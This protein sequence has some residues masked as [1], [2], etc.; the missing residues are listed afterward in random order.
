MPA[1]CPIWSWRSPLAAMVSITLIC[2]FIF[3][4]IR[5][6]TPTTTSVYEIFSLFQSVPG[7]ISTT[8]ISSPF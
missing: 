8:F 7:K 5:S 2:S 4:R 1:I 6:F 3:L